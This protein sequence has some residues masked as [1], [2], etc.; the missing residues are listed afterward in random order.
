MAAYTTSKRKRK[1]KR[2]V[3][4]RSMIYIL[5]FV[6]IASSGV[7]FCMESSSF[8]VDKIEVQGTRFT[9]D[10][11]IINASGILLGDNLFKVNRKSAK[12]NLENLYY[13]REAKISRV[14]PSTVRITIV[15]RDPFL[16]LND[17]AYYY[18]L[19]EDLTIIKYQATLEIYDVPLIS[20]V[21]VTVAEIGQVI[22]TDQMWVMKM[23][24]NMA[25]VL[26]D[27][28]VLDKVSEFYITDSNVVNIYTK[29]G[30]VIVVKNQAIFDKSLQFIYTVLLDDNLPVYIELMESGN[31]IYRPTN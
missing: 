10:E 28:E 21:V 24:A 6:L 19:D 18:Y 22:E 17:N 4:L 20:N 1:R 30:G 31:H 23:V 16:I 12:T 14:L 9:D 8:A 26:R 7:Y 15:E 5:L 29:A 3:K 25:G 27:A 2:S 13:V 11:T